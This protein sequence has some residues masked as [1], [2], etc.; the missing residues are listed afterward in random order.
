M[1]SPWQQDANGWVSVLVAANQAGIK[2]NLELVSIAPDRIRQL[3][4]PCIPHLDTLIVN[5]YEL[6][7]VANIDICNKDGT[8]NQKSCTQ[9]AQSL[10][11]YS[12]KHNGHLQLVVVHSPTKAIAVTSNNDITCLESFK[13]DNKK[14][15]SSVGAGDAFAA[16]MLYGLHE[17][18]SLESSIELAHAVAAA[19]LR[20]P[21]TVGSVESV[22][23]VLEFAHSSQ[24]K[25]GIIETTR[26]NT[27]EK[28]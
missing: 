6:G 11:S 18:W 27:K 20:S 13:V 25:S 22:A 19:S 4:L 24:N 23:L 16:G 7:A 5:E 21:T 3:A 8:I 26:N 28:L 2:T 10:F 12:E 14:I 15:S 1:D 9:A 17:G